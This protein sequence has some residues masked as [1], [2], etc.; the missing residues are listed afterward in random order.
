[1]ASFMKWIFPLIL[2][3]PGWQKTYFFYLLS[4]RPGNDSQCQEDR[5]CMLPS[6]QQLAILR[7][8]MKYFQ[9]FIPQEEYCGFLQEFKDSLRFRPLPVHIFFACFFLLMLSLFVMFC[10]YQS[11]EHGHSVFRGGS[12]KVLKSK[13]LCQRQASLQILY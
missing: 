3:D 13:L 10:D 11:C 5:F 4:E 7:N 8:K 6:D 12:V 9:N 2:C 1:M